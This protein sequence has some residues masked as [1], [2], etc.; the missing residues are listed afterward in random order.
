MWASKRL[1]GRKISDLCLCS[2]AFYFIFWECNNTEAVSWLKKR[3]FFQTSLN[4]IIVEN[5]KRSS[6]FRLP[7]LL[8][9]A[10]CEDIWRSF[11]CFSLLLLHFT[12]LSGIKL[13]VVTSV[14]YVRIRFTCYWFLSCCFFYGLSEALKKKSQQKVHENISRRREIVRIHTSVRFNRSKE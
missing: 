5:S 8:H 2:A 4:H 7:S 12:N 13:W 9:G 11:W 10:P 1:F 14:T 3:R 6:T